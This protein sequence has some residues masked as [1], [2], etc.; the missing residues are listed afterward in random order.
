MSTIK[1]SKTH[2][3]NLGNFDEGH[4]IESF[5]AFL[6]PG[7]W[8]SLYRA[9]NSLTW[10]SSQNATDYCTHEAF[11]LSKKSRKYLK[12]KQNLNKEQSFEIMKMDQAHL[13]LSYDHRIFIRILSVSNMTQQ[14]TKEV[15]ELQEF[16]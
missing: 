2:L 3:S 1:C 13:P 5:Y 15:K 10:K 14:S 7:I 12:K 8:N 6:N 9:A 4:E 16:K 11:F